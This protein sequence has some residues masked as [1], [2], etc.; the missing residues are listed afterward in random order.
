MIKSFFSTEIKKIEF[1]VVPIFSIY[2]KFLGLSFF[3]LLD[4]FTTVLLILLPSLLTISLLS[5]LNVFK[6][7]FSDNLVLFNIKV[8]SI[9]IL[10]KPW[11]KRK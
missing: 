4:K 9:V 7:N 1:F 5:A 11:I 3:D 6:A 8:N 2:V 10:L